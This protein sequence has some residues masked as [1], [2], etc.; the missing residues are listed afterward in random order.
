MGVITSFGQINVVNIVNSS[1]Q[2]KA[3]VELDF[4]VLDQRDRILTTKVDEV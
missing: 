3:T 4:P 1:N 2:R